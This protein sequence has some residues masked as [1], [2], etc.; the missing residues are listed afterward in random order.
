MI[1]FFQ[2]IRQKTTQK[3]HCEL[4]AKGGVYCA[5]HK[6]P[7]HKHIHWAILILFLAIFIPAFYSYYKKASAAPKVLAL[8]NKD[9]RGNSI[10]GRFEFLD[11]DSGESLGE[12]R[13]QNLVAVNL[14]DKKFKLKFVPDNELITSIE[15][16]DVV[17][18]SAALTKGDS[19]DNGI[20]MAIYSTTRLAVALAKRVGNLTAAIVNAANDNA[21]TNA[22]KTPGAPASPPDNSPAVP[23]DSSAPPAQIG[24]EPIVPESV[25]VSPP[26]PAPPVGPPVVNGVEPDGNI[27]IAIDEPLTPP[28]WDKVM[29]I[30]DVKGFTFSKGRFAKIAQ[31]KDL[32]KCTLWDYTNQICNGRWTK[33]AK[34]MPGQEYTVEFI[35][36]DPG[37]AESSRK[38]NVL[39][40]NKELFNYAEIVD[41]IDNTKIV[42]TPD[43]AETAPPVQEITISNADITSPNNDLIIDVVKD[44]AE[45]IDSAVK[46]LFSIDTTNL[47]ADEIKITKKAESKKLL[48]CLEYVDSENVCKRWKKEQNIIPEENFVI[49]TSSSGL[50]VFGQARD[51]L[52][53]LD[54]N[55]EVLPKALQALDI[56]KIAIQFVDMNPYKITTYSDTTS[57]NTTDEIIVDGIN[58]TTE[59]AAGKTMSFDLSSSS[60]SSAD[61]DAT[62]VG[63]DL[64]ECDDFDAVI[65]TCKGKYKKNKDLVKDSQYTFNLVKKENTSEFFESKKQIALLDK[66]DQLFDYTENSVGDDIEIMPTMPGIIK[67]IKVKNHVLN[68]ANDLKINENV[69]SP[70]ED[71]LQNYAVDPT[72]L[73]ASSELEIEAKGNTLYKCKD[74]D[75]VGSTCLGE[76][77]KYKSLNPG[78]IYTLPID[79]QDPGFMEVNEQPTKRKSSGGSSGS[80]IANSQQLATIFS[81]QTGSIQNQISTDSISLEQTLS[82]PE[83]SARQSPPSSDDSQNQTSTKITVSINQE[84]PGQIG[85]QVQTSL[86]FP[87]SSTNRKLAVK[88]YEQASSPAPSSEQTSETGLLKSDLVQTSTKATF[89]SKF[90]RVISAKKQAIIEKMAVFFKKVF[91]F[92][93]IYRFNPD[94]YANNSFRAT[95]Y[96]PKSDILAVSPLAVNPSDPDSSK[97]SDVVLN[98]NY[99]V[100]I[101]AKIEFKK[102]LKIG[103]IDTDVRVLQQFL[104]QN[105]FLVEKIGPGSPGYETNKFGIQTQMALKKFKEANAEKIYKD[106]NPEQITGVLDIETI[107]YLNSLIPVAVSKN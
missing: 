99:T 77:V 25:P 2:G 27:E 33:I 76:W 41:T 92:L 97:R 30:G 53:V 73:S 4:D 45:T 10:N 15:F 26:E 43:V 72:G 95:V 82:S 51:G 38:V 37:Y 21:N 90:V 93:G 79:N 88:D 22:T 85:S 55:L 66:E 23:E 105:S 1:R 65:Q 31:G 36:G 52:L 32:F 61:I 87:S 101:P 18:D 62:A 98:Q 68:T 104:N 57:T 54:K 89:V 64:F 107:I 34:L 16:D 78:E 100:I 69:P 63:Y 6:N 20:V 94:I 67:K 47:A 49:T 70:R 8:D 56:G 11:Q 46:E 13:N 58:Q 59:N 75:F 44:I 84:I 106:K 103:S 7:F 5:W 12:G 96:V 74:W 50:S 39:N 24:N 40:K 17:V 14:Q 83:A 42:L 19:P 81:P 71:A 86:P 80:Y 91:V 3:W 35:P 102:K 60:I 29:A 9:A 48:S 28:G